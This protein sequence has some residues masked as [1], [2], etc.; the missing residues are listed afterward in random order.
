MDCRKWF[1][2]VLCMGFSCLGCALQRQDQTPDPM[3]TI[4]FRPPTPSASAKKDPKLRG[5]SAEITFAQFQERECRSKSP[6]ER[7]QMLVR[8]R[9][10][11]Q[12]ALTQD[13]D[14][15]D[16]I[17]GLARVCGSLGE[18]DQ[19]MSIYD[20]A[21]KLHP[22]DGEVWYELGMY[23]SRRKQFAAA[24]D[25]L[26]KACGFA[27]ENRNYAKSLA[28]CLAAAGKIDESL[29]VLTRL[30]GEA[31]GALNLARTLERLRR[32]QQA[33]MYFEMALQKDPTLGRTPQGKRLYA[34]LQGPPPQQ[35]PVAQVGLQKTQ[36]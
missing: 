36:R 18:Y 22:K 10:A 33:K 34:R 27:P 24:A 8:A 7:E 2:L 32:T 1:V 4:A 25:Y 3:D 9:K 35:N 13:P 23:Y 20:E 30:Y 5:L 16:A 14:N 31:K 15:V 28:V 26:H 19:A 6:I 11:Y 17:V 29:R 12:K 21:I